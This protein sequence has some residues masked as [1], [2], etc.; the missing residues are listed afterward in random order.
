MVPALAARMWGREEIEW[1]DRSWR[2]LENE[3]QKEVDDWSLAGTVAG[4]LVT[5]R[6]T[7]ASQAGRGL[8]MLGGSGAGSMVGVVGYMVWRYGVHGG[9]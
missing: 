2:L 5:A 9:Q 6:R 1:S 8:Q 3:G 4:A 7:T